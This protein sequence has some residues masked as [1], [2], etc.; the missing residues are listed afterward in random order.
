[1]HQPSAQE[2]R[3][4][5]VSALPA[6]KPAPKAN[7]AA[8]VAARDTGESLSGRGWQRRQLRRKRAAA[9]CL[10]CG[11]KPLLRTRPLQRSR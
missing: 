1:M 4:A 6:P 9:S 5:P 11:T 8:R 10:A 2:K 7:A 3:G